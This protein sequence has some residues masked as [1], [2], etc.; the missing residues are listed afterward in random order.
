MAETVYIAVTW[1]AGDTIT[2]AKF[3]NM[4]ANDRAVD[5]MMNGIEFIERASPSTPAANKIHLYVKDKSG[6]PTI[7]AINDAGTDYELSEGRPTFLFTITGTLVIG[8]SLT[9]IIPIHRP[10]TLVR[11]FIVAKTVPTSADLIV[12]INKHKTTIWATQTNR[13]KIVDG[14][15]SG[16]QSSFNTTTIAIDDSL[17]LDVDQVGSTIAGADVTVTLRCK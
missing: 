4:V 10:L 6:I 8:A 9:P 16:N 2:E 17:T 1:T 3:D 5:A 14:A 12:D 11:Y 15:T 13:L 7:Y